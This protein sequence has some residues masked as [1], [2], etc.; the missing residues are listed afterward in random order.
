M[1]A[2]T[3]LGTPS[4][5]PQTGTVG[6]LEGRSDR[7]VIV[8]QAPGTD[9]PRDLS[10]S[11]SVRA[12]VGYGGGDFTLSAGAAFFVEQSSQR[13]VRQSLAAGAS[14][15]ITPAFG[16]ASTPAVSPDGHWVAYVHSYEGTD[17]IA[18]VDSEGAHWPA[19]LASG[20][21]FYMQP[22][23]SPDGSRLAWVEWDHPNMPWDTTG[24]VVADIAPGDNGLPRVT[25][26]QT[27]PN[28]ARGSMLNPLFAPD[29]RSLYFIN[30]PEGWW[31]VYR[32]DLA[33]GDIELLT[34]GSGEYGAPA[35]VQGERMMALLSDG[36]LVVKHHQGGADTLVTI[37]PDG[38]SREVA[39][40]DGYASFGNLA[41]SPTD[42]TI[43]TVAGSTTIPDRVVTIDLDAGAAV[44][45]LARSSSESV[46]DGALSTAQPVSWETV[47]GS[48]AH[49]IYYAPASEHFT[50]DGPP[51][52]VVMVHGGPTS[53][54]TM[55]FDPAAQFLATRGYAVLK[56]NY[57]GSTGHGRAYRDALRANWGILDVEDCQTGAEAMAAQGL[58][59][60]DRLV[61]MGG[62]AGG[63]TVLKSLVDLPGFYRA[64]VC[65]FGVSNL[66]T[67]AS[68]THKF[69]ARYLDSLLGP[70]P[71]AAA[72]YRDRSPGFHAEQIVD[73]IAVFQ[74]DID[75]VVPRE[76]SDSIVASLR[77]R[78]V[79][80]E[81][82]VY[83]G[84]GHG[85]R[86][87][88]TIEAYYKALDAFLRNYVVFA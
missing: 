77:A 15:P 21:D 80:H 85:W 88:E 65:L 20:R 22:A 84:E 86:K 40:L 82:H 24:I 55:Q 37:A 43:V 32:F 23:W 72:V 61:I 63:Y 53:E 62:S 6:W 60:R 74:G 59:D 49:G 67:L 8:V 78:G 35:W 46:P 9:A 48:E 33:S 27:V 68:D 83:E 19:R 50:C 13:I 66:F 4:F 41:A 52:M 36:T 81:Y 75:R 25:R 38:T 14:N 54:V 1:A 2:G 26:T 11:G 76:Q 3:R 58:A 44:R 16:E 73:P 5:D 42:R 29:G 79:P 64:G 12:M 39:G 51:P 69:E 45:I 30:D 17:A 10:D 31:R 56:V 47:D 57:R 71:E 7:G 34:D 70:L 28:E 87:R 18:I